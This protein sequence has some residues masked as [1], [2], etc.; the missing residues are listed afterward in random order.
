MRTLSPTRVAV[1]DC[2]SNSTRLLVADRLGGD[3]L[4]AVERHSRVTRLAAGVDAAGSLD[5]RAIERTAAV[6]EDYA[7][8]WRAL[9]AQRV[10]LVA[11]SAVRDA[12]DR[13]RFRNTV[14]DRVGHELTV[15]TG[16]EEAAATYHGAT[17]SVASE[18]SSAVIDI[19]G[20]STEIV[21]GDGT[22]VSLQLG[23]VRLA[24]RHIAGDPPASY[25]EAV[26]AVDA[27]LA[28]LPE[29]FSGAQTL[30]AVAGTAVTLAA[31]ASD[32]D[33]PD[34]AA[35]SGAVLSGAQVRQLVED[36]AWVPAA[37]RATL[38][39]ITPGREDVI[40]AGG[41][42]LARA[43]LRLRFDKVVVSDADLLD[44]LALAL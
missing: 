42:I 43:M 27:A 3:R 4:H 34:N 21:T 41:V 15:L 22:F 25:V 24:E 32:L 19:G 40:V 8:R 2:G 37:A 31:L 38:G 17:A 10:A 39:A 44:G 29:V 1:V 28:D 7:S 11:T 20:G 33:R 14:R 13:D 12:A 30:V 35:V 9:G 36:L 23:C 18:G 5:D 26:A 16:A 6:L